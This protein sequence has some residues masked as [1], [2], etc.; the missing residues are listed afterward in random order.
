LSKELDLQISGAEQPTIW[1]LL[2]VRFVLLPYTLGKV[3]STVYIR[4]IPLALWL[5]ILRFRV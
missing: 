2:V 1:R 5:I 4:C 3:R